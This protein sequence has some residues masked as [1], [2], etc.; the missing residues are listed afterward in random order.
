MSYSSNIESVIGKLSANLK[1]LKQTDPVV[2]EIAASLATSNVER[3][4]NQGKNL[5]DRNIGTYA[6]STR[7]IR[8]KEGRQVSRVDLSFTGKLSKEF[9]AEQIS[10]GWGAGFIS[11]YGGGLFKTLTIQYGDLW[12]ISASDKKAIKRII[13]KEIDKKLGD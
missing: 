12:G 6:E 3:I 13:S 8:R 4:H 5:A 7:R 1:G 9:Q 11:S 2:R 10:D